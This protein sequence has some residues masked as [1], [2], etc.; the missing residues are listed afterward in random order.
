MLVWKSKKAVMAYSHDGWAAKWKIDKTAKNHKPKR[1]DT[2]NVI[3]FYS[4][5]L[6]PLV[7]TTAVEE[8]KSD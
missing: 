4:Y 8:S 7:L 2:I 3:L 1:T 6:P 5:L